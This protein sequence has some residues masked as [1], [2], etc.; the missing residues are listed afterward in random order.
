MGFGYGLGNLHTSGYIHRVTQIHVYVYVLYIYIY[1]YMGLY[2]LL[3]YICTGRQ[4]VHRSGIATEGGREREREMNI[5]VEY[6][7][8][9]ICTHAYLSRYHKRIL[10]NAEID[11]KIKGMYEP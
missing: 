8:I 7:C 5:Y 4:E 10:E 9:Y 3:A 1:T 11:R 2:I 6:I